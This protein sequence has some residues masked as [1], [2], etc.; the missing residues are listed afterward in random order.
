MPSE[1]VPPVLADLPPDRRSY[2]QLK[3]LAL[4]YQQRKAALIGPA[5]ALADWVRA[6]A[7]DFCTPA[8]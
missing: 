4:A 7:L 2:A 6:P 3:A 1:H 5:G 8:V